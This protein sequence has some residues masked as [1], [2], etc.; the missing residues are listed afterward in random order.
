MRALVIGGAGF[1]GARLVERLA[2]RGDAVT[3]LDDLSTGARARV[4]HLLDAGRVELVRGDVRILSDVD[5][6]MAGHDV[7]FH[8][9]ASPE[10]SV[11]DDTRYDLEVG[12]IATHNVLEATRRRGVTRLVLASS[13]AVYGDAHHP[14]DEGEIGELPSTL[15]G[16]SKLA[17]E[18]LVAAF[19]RTFGLTAVVLR[20]GAVVGPGCAD[21]TL[22]ALGARVAS[23]VDALELGGDG[24]RTAGFT[25][26]DDWADAALFALERAPRPLGVFNVAP[27]DV[28]R[29]SALVSALVAR[30]ARAGLEV[31]FGAPVAPLPWP[32]VTP[33]GARL[34]ALGFAPRRASTDALADT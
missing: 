24:R 26:A 29:E 18:A 2:A 17:S 10:G 28:V 12:T 31:R 20:A 22:S 8:L 16:A 30:G 27:T 6:V 9:A 34:A 21:P 15:R 4:A 1:L 11:S 13:C 5:A 14:V 33:S 32:R 7:V 3:V 23:A 19:A 25:H